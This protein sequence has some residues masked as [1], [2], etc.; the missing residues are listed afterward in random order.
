MDFEVKRINEETEEIIVNFLEKS[1]LSNKIDIDLIKNGVVL[2]NEE[3]LGLISF[4]I[5]GKI[6]LIRYLVL[7]KLLNEND[8]SEVFNILKEI[9]K[10]KNLHYLIVFL[11]NDKTIALFK[12]CGFAC[13]DKEDI[14]IDE[15]AFLKSEY[16]DLEPLIY[17]L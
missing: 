13:K 6:G 14:Y 11:D 2:F 12:N 1:N 7:K 17:A 3:I 10:E 4:S 16:K 9:A 15:D 5:Y 8:F